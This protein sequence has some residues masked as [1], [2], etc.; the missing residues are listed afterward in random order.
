[1]NEKNL[2]FTLSDP[3]NE[4]KIDLG[5]TENAEE[6]FGQIVLNKMIGVAY[7]NI[8]LH[9][10]HG[11]LRK[12]LTILRNDYLYKSNLFKQHLKYL[13]TILDEYDK[14]YSL[15]K[16]SFL[17]TNIYE[18]GQRI[19]NDF[20]ILIDSKDISSL[21][22]L[23]ISNGFTQGSISSSN[24]IIP[25]TRREIIESRMNFGETIPFVK[26]LDNEAMT[27]D[28]NFSLDYKMASENSLISDFLGQAEYASF[29]DV[30]FKVLNPI[31][32]IIHLSCHLYK[33]ATT[34]DWVARRRD[35]MLYK[36]SDINVF[37]H[38]Y[39]SREYFDKLITRIKQWN[40]EKECYYTFENSSIIYPHLKAID[41]FEQMINSIKPD[42]LEFMKQIIYPREKK[43]FEYDLTFT[44]WFFSNDRVSRLKEIPYNRG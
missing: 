14:D 39:A 24:E 13:S 12:A 11:E 2:L 33:E 17:S 38:K 42:S 28:I 36:F 21:Q 10:L 29:E 4:K 9:T 44:D 41:G 25:A 7:D 23:L 16:G 1:M 6:L 37:I 40:L 43:L 18:C 32:F 26:L 5:R 15:L 34:Y 3:F 30:H 31:D 35:L 22:S 20:D 27:I 8:E 19:S